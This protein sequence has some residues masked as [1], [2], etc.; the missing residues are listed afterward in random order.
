MSLVKALKNPWYMLCFIWQGGLDLQA[1]EQKRRNRAMS[2]KQ[3]GA[4]KQ[5]NQAARAQQKR[6][7]AIPRACFIDGEIPVDLILPHVSRKAY[8]QIGET[9][10]LATSRVLRLMKARGHGAC[11]TCARVAT[12]AKVKGDQQSAVYL[13]RRLRPRW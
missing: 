5:R 11:C 9:K 4:A 3:K 7:R 10:A 2:R 8:V 1:R 13:G 6:E 12:R